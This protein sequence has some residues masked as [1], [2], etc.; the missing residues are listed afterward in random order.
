MAEAELREDEAT[1]IQVMANFR[2]H[3]SHS[4]MATTHLEAEEKT[5]VVVEGTGGCEQ[6]RGVGGGFCLSEGWVGGSEEG[7]GV[8]GS[9]RLSE[10]QIGGS[11]E[12]GV[13]GREGRYS[14]YET[15][16]QLQQRCT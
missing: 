12:G 5:A 8:G 3:K 9:V 15:K 4:S 6:G 2:P 1:P 10:G 13:G 11:G 14:I 16:V 7:G